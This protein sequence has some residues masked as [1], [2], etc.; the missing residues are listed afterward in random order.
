MSGRFSRGRRYFRSRSYKAWPKRSSLIRRS[1]GNMKAA[2]RQNDISNTTLFGSSLAYIIKVPADTVQ[3]F[4]TFNIWLALNDSPMF[5]TLRLCYD[6]IRI[7]NVKV[8][9]SLL[10]AL[11]MTGFNCPVFATI[12]DRNGFHPDQ[13]EPDTT[14]Y[15]DGKNLAWCWDKFASYSSFEKR[16]MSSGSAFNCTISISPS[17]MAEKSMYVS[18]ADITTPSGDGSDSYEICSPMSNPALPFKPQ[19]VTG[20]YAVAAAA[21]QSFVFSVDWEI[22]ASFR[23]MH[24]SVDQAMTTVE[25]MSHWLPS[26]N[27]PSTQETM[28]GAQRIS[29]GFT[30]MP[31]NTQIAVATGNT[32]FNIQY[33]A[34]VNLW[35]LLILRND[36]GAPRN[37]TVPGGSYYML[38]NQLYSRFYIGKGGLDKHPILLSTYAEATNG[39]VEFGET[40]VS[41]KV[42]D[43]ALVAA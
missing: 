8:K 31:V 4:Q 6:Q 20:I 15:L 24:A 27:D 32:L 25:L 16:S 26:N 21:E 13:Y 23:G 39:T 12:W 40:Y 38:A 33:V 43:F 9:F 11:S 1:L 42:V 17:N 41:G 22:D 29:A 7:N 19:I 37:F 36:S 14:D 34:T 18:T 3:G 2:K 30:L 10:Q 35:K 28:A 5:R